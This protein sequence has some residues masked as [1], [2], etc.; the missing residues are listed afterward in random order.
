MLA[1]F[2][3]LRHYG[4]EHD[5]QSALRSALQR[6]SDAALKGSRSAA[7]EYALGLLWQTW[8]LG[9]GMGSNRA[10]TYLAALAGNTGLIGAGLFVVAL[11]YHCRALACTWRREH[12][13]SALFFLG[14]TVAGVLAMLMAIPDQNWP[15]FWVLVVGGLSCLGVRPAPTAPPVARVATTRPARSA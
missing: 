2:L 13:S 7:D 9:A 6:W 5:A 14:S 1:G 8:G 11:A 10:S 15:I 12:R 4:I 3:V